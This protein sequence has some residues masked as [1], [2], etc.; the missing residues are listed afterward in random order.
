M[1]IRWTKKRVDMV[2]A[3][4]DNACAQFGVVSGLVGTNKRRR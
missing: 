1:R 4:G 3:G 2:E